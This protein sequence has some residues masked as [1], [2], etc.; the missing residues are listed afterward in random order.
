[1][2]FLFWFHIRY[3]PLGRPA[4]GRRQCAV[5]AG[6]RYLLYHSALLYQ[7]SQ[8]IESNYFIWGKNYETLWSY[9]ALLFKAGIYVTFC[10]KID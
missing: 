6:R 1:M 2:F 9:N 8:N 7:N 10:T 3:S 4:I 5:P